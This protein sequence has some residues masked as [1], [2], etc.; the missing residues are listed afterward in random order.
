MVVVTLTDYR[1]DLNQCMRSNVLTNRHFKK[2]IIIII[3]GLL[4]SKN[5]QLQI[6]TSGRHIGNFIAAM[7]KMSY[8]DPPFLSQHMRN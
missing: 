2:I 1:K 7:I 6:V 8:V 3:K 4:S 5:H